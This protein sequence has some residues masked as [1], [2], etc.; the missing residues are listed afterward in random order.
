VPDALEAARTAAGL[1]E[2]RVIVYKRPREYR[3]TY[4][5]RSETDAG[6][7]T[8]LS[9]LAG[10]TGAGPSFLYLFLP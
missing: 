5:A 3:A 7:V 9:R 8:A 6:G 4:Y 1:T 10:L 2:A